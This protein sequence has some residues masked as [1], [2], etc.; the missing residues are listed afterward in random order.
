MSDAERAAKLAEEM[1]KWADRV[2]ASGE[3]RLTKEEGFF[4]SR[5]LRFYAEQGNAPPQ[6]G[7]EAAA[8]PGFVREKVAR[9]IYDTEGRIYSDEARLFIPIPWEDADDD[10]YQ[11]ERDSFRD[12]ADAALSALR[13]GDEINGFVLVPKDPTEEMI[14]AGV[15]HRLRTTIDGGNTW[16]TDTATLYRTMVAAVPLSPTYTSDRVFDGTRSVSGAP[17]AIMKDLA[18]TAIEGDG[19]D[20]TPPYR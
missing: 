20:R 1:S 8:L 6:G 2:R 11:V 14:E 9:A 12:K 7:K 5:C 15:S 13:P 10:E 16:P 18:R 3:F 4:V 19:D 17:A